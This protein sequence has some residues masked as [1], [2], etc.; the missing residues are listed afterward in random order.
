MEK[1]FFMN[2]LDWVEKSTQSVWNSVSILM[3]EKNIE[4]VY[5]RKEQCC[6]TWKTVLIENHVNIESKSL[7]IKV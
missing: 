1:K 5:S 6:S 7:D 3:H 2:R 4:T